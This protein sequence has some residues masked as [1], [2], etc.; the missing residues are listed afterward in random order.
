M[1]VHLSRPHALPRLSHGAGPSP[2]GATAISTYALDAVATVAGAALAASG[3]LDGARH[4][5]PARVL[6]LTTSPGA[7]ACASTSSANWALLERTGTSTN[8]LS[9]AAH[10][11]AAPAGAARAHRLAAAAGYVGTES[12]RRR[13][14][15]PGRSARRWSRR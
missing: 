7:R 13:R 4:G 3:L 11:L 6:A 12:P 2:L 8:A 10:D 5:A 1:N 15:T 14:T 9:K